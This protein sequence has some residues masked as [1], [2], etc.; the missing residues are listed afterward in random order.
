MKCNQREQLSHKEQDMGMLAII[1][2]KQ[3]VHGHESGPQTQPFD[4]CRIDSSRIKSACRDGRRDGRRE[5]HDRRKRAGA[6]R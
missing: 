2:L 1:L 4:K 3:F 6:T 5:E